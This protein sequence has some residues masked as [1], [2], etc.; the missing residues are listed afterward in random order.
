MKK[1]IL[2]KVVV[3]Y[4]FWAHTPA[5]AVPTLAGAGIPVAVRYHSVDLYLDGMSTAGWIHRNCR[6]FPW[7]EEIEA[8]SKASLF[9]SDQGAAYFA[10]NWPNADVSAK[11][12]ARLGAPKPELD[13]RPDQRHRLAGDAS[14]VVVSCSSIVPLKRVAMIAK[15]V[16]SLA[17]NRSVSWHHFG[18]GDATGVRAVLSAKPSTLSA[19]LHGQ[20]ENADVL[21]FYK[22]SEPD[23]FVNFSTREGIPVSVMEAMSWGI[24]VLATAVG[25]T[26][27]AVVPGESGLLVDVDDCNQPDALAARVLEALKPGGALASSQPRQLWQQRFNAA[28]NAAK[29]ANILAELDNRLDK[30]EVPK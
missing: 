8:G 17:M 2:P 13:Q 4:S 15:F 28:T 12:V 16:C 24:P 25:G 21:A 6:Y 3:A 18:A 19:N 30:G 20:V 5:L 7:R 10:R 26:P 11:I 22:A 29:V 1:N 14:L 27:E 9:I 23:L